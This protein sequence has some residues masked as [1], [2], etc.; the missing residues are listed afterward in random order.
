MITVFISATS[1]DLK[2]YV[3]AVKESLQDAGY[4]VATMENFSAQPNKPRSAS[5]Q[6][7]EKADYF[8]GLYGRRYGYIPDN[9]KRSI[10]EQ[11]YHHA[12]QEK[13]PVFA[14]IVDA[15][16]SD[17]APGPGEDDG[18]DEAAEKQKKLKSFLSHIETALV[19][20]TFSGRQDLPAKV[21]ASL[22]RYEKRKTVLQKPAQTLRMHFG[23]NCC[24]L[25][26]NDQ[27]IGKSQ[28]T[29]DSSFRHA[30]ETYQHAKSTTPSSPAKASLAQGSGS[31]EILADQMG[32]R[33]GE[34]V[35]SGDAAQSARGLISQWRTSGAKAQLALNVTAAPWTHLPLET[36]IVPGED[37][38]LAL[39]SVHR[40]GLLC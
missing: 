39:G 9:E 7:V 25:F 1:I 37:T 22:S 12:R 24:E 38:P 11:E 27:P 34:I 26:H 32:K 23:E 30:L 6:E 10:T 31:F 16:N 36:M 4:L 15:A 5:L 18:S 21:L 2:A 35:F 29:F 17:L 3:Q 33:L 13:K 40:N 19:R 28:T 20:E 8:V 14:F